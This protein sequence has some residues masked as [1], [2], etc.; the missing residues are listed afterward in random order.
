M[1]TVD[2]VVKNGRLVLKDRIV[3]SDM[4]VDQGKIVKI[5]VAEPS[6]KPDKV[7][8]AK[9]NLVIPGCIDIHVHSRE[10][11]GV[12]TPVGQEN[13]ESLTQ[14]AAAGGYTTVFDMPVTGYP[15]TTTVEGF[16]VK[17]RVAE[18][19]CIVDY[20]FYGGAGFG[21]LDELK[22][23]AAEGVIGFKTFT[24]EL[25]AEEDEEQ[26][27]GVVLGADGPEMFLQLMEAVEKTGRLLSVHCEDDRLITHLRRSLKEAGNVGLDAYYRSAP[28]ASE[29]LEVAR[30]ISLAKV[31]SGARVN[32]A[33][34]STA[35]GVSMVKEAKNSCNIGG[36]GW[37]SAETC[38]HYLLLT[39]KDLVEKLGPYGKMYPPLRS[40]L[41]RESLWR[42]LNEGVIDFLATDHAPHLREAKE[43]GWRNIFDAAAGVPGL[44]TALPLMLTQMNQGRISLFRLIEVMCRN[45]AEAFGISSR[46]GALEVGRDADFVVVDPKLELILREEDMHTRS[47]AKVFDGWQVAGAPVLTAVRGEVVMNE[48]GVVSGKPGYGEYVTPSR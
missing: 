22:G 14:A 45:P 48:A 10:P 6:V 29:F 18:K 39:N 32:I 31:V 23:L 46:K 27:R 38:P 1:S 13:F 20:G 40:D 25:P 16:K 30:S 3:E 8:D 37:V 4:V 43:S 47:S 2:L 19:R 24:R 5:G 34:L 15:P 21:N 41:D 42:G 33:H 17:R 7:M 36:G 9:G 26:W 12:K 35:E 44:E 11:H 28:N